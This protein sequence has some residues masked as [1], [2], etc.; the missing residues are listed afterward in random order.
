MVCE[1]DSCLFPNACHSERSEES[2]PLFCPTKVGQAGD[3]L[4]RCPA[5]AT[6]FVTAKAGVQG[7]RFV[8]ELASSLRSVMAKMATKD[9]T[10]GRKRKYIRGPQCCGRKWPQRLCHIRSTASAKVRR[11]AQS[12]KN[13]EFQVLGQVHWG[14]VFDGEP[15]AGRIGFAEGKCFPLDPALRVHWRFRQRLWLRRTTSEAPTVTASTATMTAREA[16]GPT[17]SQCE[18]NILKAANPSSAAMP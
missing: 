17:S 1:L 8:G 9:T 16:T 12:P 15:S 5:T 18:A 4:S 14:K 7:Y 2:P 13:A 10:G 6:A 3:R 11:S